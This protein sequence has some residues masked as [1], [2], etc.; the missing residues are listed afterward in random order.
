MVTLLATADWVAKSH[1]SVLILGETGVGKDVIAERIHRQSQRASRPFLRINCAAFSPSL[2]ESELFGHEKGSFTGATVAAPGLLRSGEGGTVFLDEIGD[3][4]SEL[5]AKLLL[6]IERREVLAVGAVRPRP[7]DVR[8]ISATNGNLGAKMAGGQF[9]QDLYFRLNGITLRIPPLRE[10]LSEIEGLA[11][12]FAQKAAASLG[13]ATPCFS[14]EAL[15]L[16]KGYSWP[17][18]LRELRAI[19]ER[20]I[21][22]GRAERIE[23]DDLLFPSSQSQR[24]IAGPT[25]VTSEMEL[26]CRTL[27]QFGGNQS[28]AAKELG[29][30]RNTF[31]ARLEK[32]GIARPH[33]NEGWSNRT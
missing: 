24:G 12:L 14:P 18:N 30:A 5:Q 7:I 26:I 9:R 25:V 4:P 27:A 32:Y 21:V 19:V 28:R 13:Q 15:H 16:L 23:A 10:R 11:Q 33:K 1:L 6:V 2:L 20:A 17:G 22:L 8:F 3:F 29:M 31:I